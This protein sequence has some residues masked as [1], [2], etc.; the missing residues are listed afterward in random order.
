MLS[1]NNTELVEITDINKLK[2][3]RDSY[4]RNTLSWSQ[5]CV[6]YYCLDNYIRWKEREPTIKHLK[7]YTL[8]ECYR[9]EGLYIIVDR[10]QLFAGSLRQEEHNENLVKALQLLDWSGG[11]KVS[12]ILECHRYSVLEVVNKKQLKLE[13]DS[14]TLMYFMTSEKAKN[15]VI[16]C[17]KGYYV[18][19]LTAKDDALIV[20]NHW[21][22]RHQGSLFL[23]NRLIEWN[24]N[25]GV[26]VE[27]TDELVAWCL[28]LQGGFLGALQVKDS[29][30]RLGLG[31]V[32]T[33]A[34]SLALAES[35]TDIMALVNEENRPSRGMFEKLGFSVIARCYWL[36][37]FPIQSHYQWPSGE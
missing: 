14:L 9:S 6:G 10:Y 8:N 34:I 15:L 20:D 27:N 5:H 33:R 21:P 2:E 36:R 29:H 25:M 24:V 22:N 11:L 12:S 31:S 19:P 32:V 3:L 26:Y 16:G 4:R 35:G 1:K 17:P 13:Y 37:T 18:K 30:K 28:R 23:I 7:I